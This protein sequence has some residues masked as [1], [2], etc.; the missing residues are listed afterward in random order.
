MYSILLLF[1]CHV[2]SDSLQHHGLR[3]TRLLCPWD[4]P[5]KDTG[6]GCHFHLHLR[7]KNSEKKKKNNKIKTDFK[8]E[9]TAFIT[10]TQESDAMGTRIIGRRYLGGN[11]TRDTALPGLENLE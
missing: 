9:I 11:P 7:H 6:V 8:M 5:G 4:F 1:S 3:P 10:A 2:M